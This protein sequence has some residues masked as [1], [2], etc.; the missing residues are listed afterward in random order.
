MGL[1]LT[2]ITFDYAAGTELAQRALGGVSLNV[3][4]GGLTLVVGST[5][6]GK[7]TLLRAAAGMIRPSAGTVEADGR[8]ISRPRDARGVVGLV[9]QRPESQFFAVTVAEDVAFGPRNLGAS[10]DEALRAALAA[11]ADVGVDPDAFAQRSPFTLS[12]GEARRIALAGVLAMRPDYLLLDEPTAGLDGPGRAAVIAA[13]RRAR[14][15][16]GVVVVTHDA[17]EFLTEADE[18]VVLDAGRSLFRGTPG[19]MLETLR[20]GPSGFECPSQIVRT[21]MLAA[22]R[23]GRGVGARLVLDVEGA[24]A[25]IAAFA[26][27]AS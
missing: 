18:I 1:T 2:D 17:D 20:S 7:S 25:S 3:E 21:Q 8:T 12:G 19:C 11:L 9:F 5:G 6:S 13:V 14:E 23:S 15:R 27:G 24:A 4:M 10:E 16:A 26:G 22:E